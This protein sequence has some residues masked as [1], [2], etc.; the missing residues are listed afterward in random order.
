MSTVPLP[1]LP[2]VVIYAHDPDGNKVPVAADA[3]GNIGGSGGSVDTSALQTLITATNAAIAAMDGHVDGLETFASALNGYVDQL[4]GYTD[5]IETLITS[6]NTKLDGIHTDL[7][8]T[9]AAYVDG[10][11]ALIGTTN[12]NLATLHTDNI[13]TRAGKTSSAS[14]VETDT[15]A[16]G[17]GDVVGADASTAGCMTFANAAAVAGDNIITGA[18]LAVR[19]TAGTAASIISGETSYSLKLYS[20]TQPA[21]Q[22]GNALW[23][24]VAGDL[25]SFL[26]EVDLGTLVDKGDIL[27]VEVNNLGKQVLL[28]STSLFGVLVTNGAYTQLARTFTVTIHTTPA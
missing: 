11:E 6:T 24:L 4:E 27:Y 10:L 20:V 9:L 21:A 5:G 28:A 12:T 2:Q 22:L 25:S 19:I 18:S 26:G 8:T 16:I 23:N 13:T 15:S 1:D 17:A 14:I 3:D 7:G